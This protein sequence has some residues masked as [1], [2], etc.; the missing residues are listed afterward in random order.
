MANTV[1]ALKKSPTPSASPADLANGELA[2][3]YSDG[4]LFYKHANGTIVSF[5]SA[6][7]GFS[8]V[9]ANGS[10]IIADTP[11]DVLTL[12]PGTNVQIEGDV[13]NDRIII[14]ATVTGSDPGP[15]FAQANTANITADLAYG[16]AN[17]AFAIANTAN[18]TADI[19]FGHANLAFEKA[20]TA[21]TDT[22][23]AFAHAN[24][25]F[26][27]ANSTLN[28]ISDSVNTTRYLMFANGVS[29]AVPTLNVATGLTFNPSSNSLVT[30]SIVLSGTGNPLIGTIQ[31]NNNFS[32][33]LVVRKKGN[34]SDIDGS[35]LSGAE[36]GYNSFFG[37]NGD[38]FVRGAYIIVR[39]SEDWNNTNRGS[40]LSFATTAI[41]SNVNVE[42]VTI[43]PSGNLL[44]GRTGSIVGQN[45]KLDVNGA[46][47]ASSIILTN[48][49]STQ[50]LNVTSNVINFGT[51]MSILPNGMIMIY[52]DINMLA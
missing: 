51:A 4:K 50:G 31:S 13:A 12:V 16:Q 48:N 36:L 2:I 20:N 18:I 47:N 22:A 9:N 29:G 23:A 30:G 14:S 32:A 38:G 24:A 45:V 41:G 28:V 11:G 15:A 10:L 26:G 19:A 42:N 44:I 27:K 52:G 40:R 25:A 39:T 46:I 43:D 3:N 21:C 35:V 34:P 8:T 5:G 17:Q 1:I 7:D 33:G 37:W 49:V 6:V